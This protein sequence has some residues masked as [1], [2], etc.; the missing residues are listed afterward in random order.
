MAVGVI[1]LFKVVQIAQAQT[2]RLLM[3]CDDA[4]VG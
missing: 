3:S 2:Q 1:D 4:G